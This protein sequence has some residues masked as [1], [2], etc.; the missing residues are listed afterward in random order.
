MTLKQHR[1]TQ[2][3]P[4]GICTNTDR[5]QKVTVVNTWYSSLRPLFN[6]EEN[7]TMIPIVTDGIQSAYRA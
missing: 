7:I 2:F 4:S 3:M 5:F 6:A 1:F